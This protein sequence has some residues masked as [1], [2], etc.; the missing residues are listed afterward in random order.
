MH[1]SR[2]ARA[3]RWGFAALVAIVSGCAKSNPAQPSSAVSL[4][5][6]VSVS[7]NDGSTVAF[8]SQ[9]VKLVVTNSTSASAVRPTYTFEVASD[10]AFAA[11]V[12]TKTGVVEGI[13][14]QTTAALDPLPAST[15]Y[16]WHARADSGGTTGSFGATLQFSVG[17]AVSLSAPAP[18]S[19]ANG[20]SILQSPT[21]T[22]ANATKTGLAGSLTYTF[23]VSDS[24]AFSSLAATG[25]VA[26]GGG[27][28]TS[29]VVSPPLAVG[30]TYYWR[31]TAAD[32]ANGVSSFPSAVQSFNTI[33]SQAAQIA[34]Q[35]GQQ[36]WNATQPP[37][38]NGHTTLGTGWDVRT[39]VPF[40]GGTPYVSPQLEALRLIDLVDRGMAP[41]D[42][43]V[44][45]QQN[46]YPTIAV[47]YSGVEVFGIYDQY[48]ADIDPVTQRP[49]T[50]GVWNLVDRAE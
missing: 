17:G 1:R 10:A 32:A 45:M 40:G 39:K 50:N 9:P 4:V 36:L 5:A 33:V 22:V 21:L 19:P 37:G 24:T 44:W 15:R 25:T 14:G 42:A 7:P 48:L 46:N 12:Q 34:A 35:E 20:A 38:V 23:E 6:P 3:A 47:Y 31:A 13:N 11:K 29:Y 49:S 8:I 2:T 18:I 26:E 27:L 43:I 41:G 28:Q 30:K 16:F